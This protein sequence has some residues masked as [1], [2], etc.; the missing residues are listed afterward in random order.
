MKQPIK[1]PKEV[2]D[3]LTPRMADEF[4]AHYTYKAISNWCANVGFFK[5]AA[6]FQKESEDELAHAKKIEDFLVGWNVIPQLPAIAKPKLDYANLGEVIETAYNM[7]YELYEAYEE[8]SAK[9]FKTGDLCVF[10]FLQEYRTIQSKSVAEY[11]D[12][13]NILQGCN[14]GD[15]FQML[16][17]EKKLF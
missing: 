11:S 15:K 9:V 10:D 3:L 5:A 4:T 12:K 17:L 6:F 8:T 14:T 1:L 7:E 16:M 2:V 13:I